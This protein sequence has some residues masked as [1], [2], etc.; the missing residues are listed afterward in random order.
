MFGRSNTL[1]ASKLLRELHSRPENYWYR[2][3][4]QATLQLF[5]QMSERVPAYQDYLAK[6]GISP[7]KIRSVADL[8]VVPPVDK[9]NYLRQYSLTDL[10]WD[11]ELKKQS[12]VIS[13]TSG[14]TGEPFYFPRQ[15]EQDRQYALTAEIYLLSNFQINKRSTLYIN[16]FAMGAWIGG[17]FTYQAIRYVAESGKYPL[18]IINPGIFKNEIIKA[19]RHLG[20]QFDQIIIGGYPPLIK[21]TIDLAASEGVNWEDY[22]VNFIFSAEAFSERFRDYVV[23]KANLRNVYTSTLNHYGTVDLGTMAHETPL[24]I[25][26]RRLLEQNQKAKEA[27]LPEAHRSPT[28]AQYIP[29]Q[30]FFEED[31]LNLFASA[32]S[33]LPLCRY[34]LKDYGGIIRYD[35]L[36]QQLADHH[37]HID[38]ELDM[39][40]LTT[41][42][43]NLP[44]VYV[45]E[46]RDFVVKL[47]GANVY[48]E[49][50]RN[51]LHADQF[52][53]I[54]TGKCTLIIKYDRRQNQ[55]LEINIE[56]KFGASPN[57]QLEKELSQAIV[58][59]LLQ[60]NSEYRSN[61]RESAKRQQPKVVLWPFE[62]QRHFSVG[63]KQ[64]WVKHD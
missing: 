52:A 58:E 36:E 16:G 62:D 3:G 45:Y 49:T 4:E 11:G 28:I 10:C 13:T 54:L 60:E 31:N 47:Y 29:E 43:W 39:H 12:W 64:K 59:K 7:Q 26:V 61:Y 57:K 18:S 5:H 56:M 48:P 35:D 33:G 24:S 55:Y 38:E 46:R 17:L 63:G 27:V 40:Q 8:Q 22:H 6:E 20:P 53:S 32:R 34:N 30:F 23:Q 21:D 41:T 19:V 14:S 15:H 37:I 42:R 25:L 9:D 44:Y 50:I 51:V 2:R 1:T